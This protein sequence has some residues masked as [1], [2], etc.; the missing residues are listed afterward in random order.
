[1]ATGSHNSSVAAYE[2]L[3]LTIPGTLVHLV[4]D[5]ESVLLASGNFTIVRINQQ[6]QRIVVLVRAGDSLQWPL[7]SDEQVVKLDPIHYV[8]SLPMAPTMNQAVDGSSSE[9]FFL[10]DCLLICKR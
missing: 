8:F 3:L 7:V 9:V 5:Q 4:D 1:M 2:E 6:S 10:S